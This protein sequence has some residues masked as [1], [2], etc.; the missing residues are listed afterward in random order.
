MIS[1]ECALSLPLPTS[2]LLLKKKKNVQAAADDA[3]VSTQ[4]ATHTL[5]EFLTARLSDGA[6]ASAA[7]NGIEALAK[8]GGNDAPA[9]SL[10]FPTLSFSISIARRSK[11]KKKEKKDF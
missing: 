9:P 6:S 1:I 11:K 3:L 8:R 4:A 7:A 10:T 2:V 5:A